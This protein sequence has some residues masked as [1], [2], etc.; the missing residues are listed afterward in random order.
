MRLLLIAFQF[1]TIIPLPIT[2]RCEKDDL[3]LSLIH[4]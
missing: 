2:L 1:L 4:I 3:G